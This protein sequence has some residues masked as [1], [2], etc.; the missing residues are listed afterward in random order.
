M[1]MVLRSQSA[2]ADQ[3]AVR[4]NALVAEAKDSPDAARG[5][6]LWALGAAR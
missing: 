6:L 4:E 2:P 3:L 1:L 5:D